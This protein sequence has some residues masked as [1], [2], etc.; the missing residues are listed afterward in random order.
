MDLSYRTILLL[1]FVLVGKMAFAQKTP[2]ETWETKLAGLPLILKIKTDSLTKKKIAV[3]DSPSQGAFNIPVTSLQITTDSLK[4]FS[5]T[6]GGGFTGRFN[7][8]HAEIVGKWSQGGQE[9]EAILKKVDNGMELKRPQTPVA[10]FPYEIKEVIYYNN[11]KTIKYGA[12]LTLPKSNQPVPVVILITG[13]GQEDRD[14]TLFGHK[15]FWVL[16]DHLSRNGIAV[17]RVDDR[18]VGESTG[19]VV[20]ATSSDFANDVLQSVNFVKTQY[21]I[22]TKHIGLIG[23][24][25]GGVIAPIAAT[26]SK[27]ISFIVSLAGVGVTGAEL[28]MA[29]T[30]GGYKSMGFGKEDLQR[31]ASLTVLMNKLVR[32]YVNDSKSKQDFEQ[33]FTAWRNQQ[34]DDFLLRAKLKGPGADAVIDRMAS[35]YFNP[36]MRYFINY[37][38]STA[39]GKLTI[40][41][42]ALNGEKDVQVD[43]TQNLAG[44]RLQL[45]K[46]GNKNFKTVSLPSLNHLFQTAKTGTIDE[47]ATIEE[48]FN[49]AALDLITDWIKIQVK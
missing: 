10:P 19:D 11:D 3:Y 16:A 18:G 38:P 43:A 9:L 41:I 28:I 47:Y 44:F 13:S 24:S 2:M 26:R 1:I 6:I 35:Q 20:N 5:A 27:D 23:H 12:T 40:P 21:G 42:L 7:A 46:A 14:E 22:D 30:Q 17:L 39:L 29:Q 48:T 8:N 36:W 49:P 33:R 31:A 45:T 25:E 4:A 15:P 32:E 37:D 34:P